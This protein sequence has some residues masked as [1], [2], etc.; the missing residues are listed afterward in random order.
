VVGTLFHRAA[1]D[2]WYVRYGPDDNPDPQADTLSLVNPGPMEGF[3]PGEIVRV[4]G[5][6]L[7]PAPYEA[8]PSYRVRAI[9]ALP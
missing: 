7:D 2:T 5:E 8:S 6:L 3:R 9:Q 1:Q 4:E